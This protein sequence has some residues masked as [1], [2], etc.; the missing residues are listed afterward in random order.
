MIRKFEVVVYWTDIL[1]D[2]Y[3][4]TLEI[5]ENLNATDGFDTLY[6]MTQWFNLTALEGTEVLRS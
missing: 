4:V 5:S 6:R 3:C 2:L 1:Q